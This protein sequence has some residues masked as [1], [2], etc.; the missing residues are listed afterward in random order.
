[1]ISVGL[2]LGNSKI[3]CIVCDIKID[4]K[5]KPLSLVSNPTNSFKKSYITDLPK[6]KKEV[7]NKTGVDLELEIKIIGD[8]K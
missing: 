4:G 5:V 2:D 6:V 1:M 8:E 3:S 7:Q